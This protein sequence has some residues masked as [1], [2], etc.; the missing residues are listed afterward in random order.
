[1][2]DL[3][4]FVAF[5]SGCGLPHKVLSRDDVLM[6]PT[7]DIAYVTYATKVEF[8]MLDGYFKEDG[9]LAGLARPAGSTEP[10]CSQWDPVTHEPSGLVTCRNCGWNEEPH[11]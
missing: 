1:M 8:N 6:L 3:E 5:L 4:R 2:S 9:S 11:G 10:A 7:D